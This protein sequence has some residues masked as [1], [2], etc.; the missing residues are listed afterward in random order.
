MPPPAMG[1]SENAL[2]KKGGRFTPGQAKLPSN[3]QRQE[4]FRQKQDLLLAIHEQ[5]KLSWLKKM[6]KL[7][8]KD[9]K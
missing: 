3:P 2:I 8:M 9:E 5:E 6:T 4:E 1:F 7:Q